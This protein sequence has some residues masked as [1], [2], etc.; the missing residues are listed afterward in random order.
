MQTRHPNTLIELLDDLAAHLPLD[1]DYLQAKL[2]MAWDVADT[3]FDPPR[4]ERE[5]AI[6]LADSTRIT[7]VILV[8]AGFEDT[9]PIAGFALENAT[10]T[11]I[12]L[13]ERFGTLHL[14]AFPSPQGTGLGRAWT[15]EIAL[16]R[17]VIRFGF[18]DGRT[19]LNSVSFSVAKR[20]HPVP[21]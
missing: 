7:H 13:E 2:D 10:L 21:A 16:Q 9:T 6:A 19:T 1:K 15:F 5:T 8:P 18:P 3:R 11:A 20:S 14:V 12:Q 17:G 4:F